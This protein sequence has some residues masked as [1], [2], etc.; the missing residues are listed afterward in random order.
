MTCRNC[1][2]FDLAAVQSK[3]GAVMRD[4]VGR[5]FWKSTEI[6]PTSVRLGV[7]S[8]RPYASLMEPND[9]GDCP[10]FVPRV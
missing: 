5:C 3:S 8:H 6:L 7:T 1:K 4:R 10:C 9:G 2:L